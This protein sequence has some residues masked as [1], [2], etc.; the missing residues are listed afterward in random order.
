M[1]GSIKSALRISHD[2]L[3]TDIQNNIDSALLDLR[4]VGVNDKKEDKLVMKAVELY[5]KWQYD[6]QGKGEQYG[7]NYEK[8]RDSLSMAGD[9]NNVQ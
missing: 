8:L 6:Y 9:Y 1:L 5:C 7:K 3:N 2:K 4:R